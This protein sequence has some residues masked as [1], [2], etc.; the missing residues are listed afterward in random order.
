MTLSAA[1][2]FRLRLAGFTDY[3]VMEM[4]NAKTADGKD[5]PPIDINSSTWKS[6]MESREKWISDKINRGWNDEQIDNEVMDYYR[7]D[8]R[9][10]PFDFLKLEYRPP[11]KVDYWE[12]I[13]NRK[14]AAIE[15]AMGEY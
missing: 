2:A 9:R 7:R 11:K 13:R 12:A 6:M 15:A 1:D 10:S 5:Q 8:E 4:A 3:E 14:R